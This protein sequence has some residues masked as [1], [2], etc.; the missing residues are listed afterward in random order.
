MTTNGQT[1]ENPECSCPSAAAIAAGF[2]VPHAVHC[3]ISL[4]KDAEAVTDAPVRDLSTSQQNGQR[5]VLTDPGPETEFCKIRFVPGME[6]PAI[7]AYNT[8]GKPSIIQAGRIS[9]KL[10]GV[11]EIDTNYGPGTALD[12]QIQSDNPEL[13]GVVAGSFASSMLKRLIQQ[14]RIGSMIEIV[15]LRSTDRKHVYEVY[16]LD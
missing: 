15:R 16:V 4:A 10:I 11:R 12:L 14:V 5:R 7:E 9:G 6:N 1:V 2:D 3:Y 8:D 13:S